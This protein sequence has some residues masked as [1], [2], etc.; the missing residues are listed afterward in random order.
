MPNTVLQVKSSDLI[1]YFYELFK[2]FSYTEPN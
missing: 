2:E 1:Y